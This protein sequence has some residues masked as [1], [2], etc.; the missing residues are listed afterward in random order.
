MIASLDAAREVAAEQAAILIIAAADGRA[1]EDVD[2]HA[3][4]DG[5]GGLGAGWQPNRAHYKNSTQD[6]F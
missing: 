5:D 1:E 3:F 6:L 4:V 2:G